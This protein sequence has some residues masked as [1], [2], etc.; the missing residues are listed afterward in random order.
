[1][2]MKILVTGAKG[3]VGRNLCA[4]LKNIRDGKARNYGVD[5]EE[6]FEYDFDSKPEDLD[7]YCAEADF[8]FNLAGVNRPKDAKEFM[9]GNFGFGSTL[10]GKLKEQGNTC[11]VML[12]SSQQASLAGRFGN[13]EYGR[14]KKAGED[15]FLQYG[16]ET[17][18]KVLVYRFP[19]LFGKWCRPNYNSAVATFCNAI[20]N[21]LPYTVNDS[22]VELELLYI[23]DLVDEMIGCLRGEEHRCD[24]DG[25][26]VFPLKDG[27]YCYVPVTHRATL[28]EIVT[29]LHRFEDQ[30]KTLIVPEIPAG[31][32]AKKLYSTFLSYLPREKV[33]FP[34]KTNVD[35]RGSFTELLK[36]LGNGQFSVNISNPGVTKGQHWHNT[37]W[38][39][40]IVVSGRALIQER[41]IDSDEILN[42]EVS[43]D[44]IQ[45]V[46]MLPG[47]THNII[48]LS[49]T[50]PLVTLMW[51][52]ELFDPNRPDTFFE[53]VE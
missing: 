23:D 37:K 43:G 14:S 2:S 5:I 35:Q 24:F 42:F 11:P 17:G 53:P 13:S 19:N 31:S 26:G 40:F 33:A 1:M 29:L 45:A 49:D 41:R 30:R 27:K 7:R 18:A 34:L 25:L 47:Y 51:A 32:F 28:G 46:H 48:N 21:D 12:S 3:F 10:L 52:N 39:F 38:E 36:T 44:C 20:A 15:L 50:E 22:S 4:Q 16:Y 9:E 6:V 8:V